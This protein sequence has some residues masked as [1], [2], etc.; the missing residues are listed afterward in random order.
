MHEFQ[1][2]R[3]DQEL[4]KLGVI[5]AQAEW[6]AIDTESNSMFAFRERIC[7]IQINVAGSI[8]IIDPLELSGNAD[9]LEALRPA[10]EDATIPCFLHGA[11]YDVCCFKREYKIALA[12][13][14]DSQ[15]AA[16][17]LAYKQ[18]GYGAMVN[19]I[20]EVELAKSHSQYNWGT[21]P[22][23][24]DA[25]QYAIDDV[26]YLPQVAIALQEKILEAELEEEILIANSAVMDATARYAI[27]NPQAVYRVKGFHR[28]APA[29][30]PVCF[31]LYQWRQKLAEEKDLPPGRIL[32]NEPLIALSQK[33]PTNFGSLK[34]IR[35]KSWI[36]KE[37]GEELMG[38]I[39]SALRDPPQLPERENQSRKIDSSEKTRE[40]RLKDWRRTESERREVP[41]QVVLPARA[42]SHLKQFGSDKLDE[43]PQLGK[44]RIELY[45]ETIQRLCAAKE[46]TDDQTASTEE[47]KS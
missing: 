23:D 34:R 37:H 38:I 4:D 26:V 43:V 20:C 18:T 31:A 12:G 33:S 28:L 46:P 16:S 45:G 14:W 17:Y 42:I 36:L 29:K 27:D 9:D 30:H 6:I 10:L 40:Q 15:Q 19:E 25:L 41:F 44:K 22:L 3:T 1:W 47:Q 35:L 24:E 39:K 11:E 8:Y 7:L 21:R 32:A 2:V 13:V 5:C